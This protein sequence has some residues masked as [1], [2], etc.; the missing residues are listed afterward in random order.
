MLKVEDIELIRKLVLIDGLSQNEAAERLGHSKRSIKRALEIPEPRQYTLTAPRKCAVAETVRPIVQQWLLEDQSK[1]RKQRHTQTRIYERLRDEYQ[2]TGSRRTISTLVTKLQGNTPK[3]FCPIEYPP[4]GEVQID[5]GQAY[6]PSG[7]G[8]SPDSVH[9]MVR[10]F[11]PT[12][13]NPPSIR[14]YSVKPFSCE[15]LPFAILS[16]P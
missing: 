2:F 13:R 14:L 4:A 11:S 5:W 12:Q 3:V 1:P 8:L 16:A 9:R 6:F 15:G 10:A 7:S